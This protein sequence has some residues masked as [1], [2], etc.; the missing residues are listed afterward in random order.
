MPE[1][2][3][4]R[5]QFAAFKTPDYRGKSGPL[6]LSFV[7]SPQPAAVA[8]AIGRHVGN[9][10]IRNRIRRRL[11][12]LIVERATPLQPG[13]YLIKCGIG[14]DLLTYDDLRTHLNRALDGLPGT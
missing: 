5:R 2:V 3:Q 11:R 7:A 9:A 14:T 12:S 10:V 8:Y 13:T 1:R 4:L 6:R